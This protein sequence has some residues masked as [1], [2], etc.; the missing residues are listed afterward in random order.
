MTA[1]KLDNKLNISLRLP[2]PAACVLLFHN[3]FV[4]RNCDARIYRKCTFAYTHMRVDEVAV[5]NGDMYIS[6]E[7]DNLR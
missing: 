1:W 5:I 6:R 2:L 3:A 7:R 4:N